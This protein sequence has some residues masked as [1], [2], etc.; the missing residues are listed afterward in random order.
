VYKEGVLGLQW[1]E[2]GEEGVLISIDITFGATNT[3]HSQLGRNFASA[4]AARQNQ[5]TYSEAALLKCRAALLGPITF[6]FH[7]KSMQG[8]HLFWTRFER[9][10][11]GETRSSSASGSQAWPIG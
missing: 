11:C 7:I 3:S 10:E 6:L 9:Q 5:H 2:E 8:I 4:L 1:G